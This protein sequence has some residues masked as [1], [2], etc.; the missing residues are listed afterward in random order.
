MIAK[1]V[2]EIA[3]VTKDIK[4]PF[5]LKR[6]MVRPIMM[7]L[8]DSIIKKGEITILGFGRFYIFRKKVSK[9]IGST[10][11]KMILTVAFRPSKLFVKAVESV[12][13]KKQEVH[14]EPSESSERGPVPSVPNTSSKDM[15][16][17]GDTVDVLPTMSDTD[18]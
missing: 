6:N 5:S 12:W 3:V 9:G 10:E 4:V 14:I 13:S 17:D 8:R 16:V 7:G 18:W 11:K 1:D 2:T 15:S